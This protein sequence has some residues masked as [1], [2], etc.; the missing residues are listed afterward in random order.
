MNDK[1]KK[2]IKKGRPLTKKSIVEYP[3]LYMVA[4]N[5]SGVYEEVVTLHN[6]KDENY[7]WTD[8]LGNEC[9]Y[10]NEKNL[11]WNLD[12]NRVEYITPIKKEAENILTIIHIYRE[13]LISRL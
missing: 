12:V 5:L 9:F 10:Y 6:D 8:K 7:L 13:M 4:M 1:L 2:R 3:T 11:G